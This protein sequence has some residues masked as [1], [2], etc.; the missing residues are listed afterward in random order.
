MLGF[1][2]LSEN[3][4]TKTF[5][6]EKGEKGHI[7]IAVR[8]IREIGAESRYKKS[9][10][11]KMDNPVDFLVYEEGAIKLGTRWEDRVVTYCPNSM[12]K[13]LYPVVREYNMRSY[14][15]DEVYDPTTSTLNR[16]HM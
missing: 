8:T 12:S 7:E 2:L 11:G 1:I 6:K 14:R 16:F 10:W 15:I 9:K 5:V 13:K 4:E 3:N